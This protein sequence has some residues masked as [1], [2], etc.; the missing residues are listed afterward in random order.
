[1]VEF[2]RNSDAFALG[3][4][5]DARLRSTV[6]TIIML[7]RSPD[8]SVLIDRLE[9]VVRLMPMFRQRVVQTLP[10]APP[11]WVYDSDFDLRNHVRRITAPD[12]GKLDSVLEMARR[13][14]ME[15]FDRAWPC[16]R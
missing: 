8:W 10:P 16:G 9:R 13:A 14:E 7:D 3:M 6:V 1:M 2:M 12:P 5:A 4:E 11:R 15:E